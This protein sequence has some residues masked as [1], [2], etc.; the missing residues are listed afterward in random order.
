MNKNITKNNKNKQN[1]YSYKIT[2]QKKE[3]KKNKK[4][5]KLNK[6]KGTKKKQIGGDKLGEG[7]FGCVISPPII[8][9]KNN[10]YDNKHY[11]S[12]LITIEN[13]RD[14]HDI[15]EELKINEKIHSIDKNM[16]YFITIVDK[17]MLKRGIKRPD[18]KFVTNKIKSNPKV[19]LVK[20]NKKT[21]NLIMKNAGINVDDIL[22]YKEYKYARIMIRNNFKKIIY[23]LINGLDILHSA[24]IVH[25]DIKPDNLSLKITDTNV[26]MKYIDFGMAEDKKGKE[27]GLTNLSRYVYGTPGY[28]S[29]DMYVLCDIIKYLDSYDIDD[30][31]NINFKRKLV[32]IIYK[33]IK[34]NELSYQKS[35]N[36]NKITLNYSTYELKKSEDNY[37]RNYNIINKKEI[38]SI[39]NNF[40]KTIMLGNDSINKLLY[41]NKKGIV[42]KYDIYALGI[43]LFRLGETLGNNDAAFYNLIKNMVISN[44][45]ERYNIEEC[46][47][48]NYL[49]GMKSINVYNYN[50]SSYLR[51]NQKKKSNPRKTQGKDS[52]YRSKSKDKSKGKGKR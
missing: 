39:Y 2:K 1:K 42:Y 51:Q 44:P 5:T 46:L 4:E 7:S 28:I 37:V 9:G 16:D 6:R 40:I 29:P 19:C 43:S 20:K 45:N 24:G 13:K 33:K 50:S 35:I 8:C 10:E 36:L 48:H 27:K 14:I 30:F 17:C 47:S 49:R 31:N 15:N 3:T 38:N 18:L 32:E 22:I 25:H 26:E 12:K 23:N 41:R 11:A 21:V 52:G 34:N